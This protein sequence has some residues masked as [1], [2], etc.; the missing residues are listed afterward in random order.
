MPIPTPL[1]PRT[2]ALCESQEWRNWAGYLAA[3]TYEPTHEREYYAIRNAAALI[4]VSPLFKY[5]VN[6]SDALRLVNRIITR[7][8]A[9]CAVGQVMYSP[10]CDD[11]GMV[12]DDGTIARLEENRFRI[13]AAEPNLAW[14]QDCGVGLNAQVRDV[15][16]ELATLALQGPNA[17][18]ILLKVVND[19]NLEGLRYYRFSP[20]NMGGIPLLISRTGYTGDLG[21]EL[22]IDPQTAVKVWDKIFEE[23]EGFGIAPVGIVALDIARIEAGLVMLQV[24]YISARKALIEEQKSSPFELGLGWTVDLKK[25]YFIGR[26]ALLAEKRRG[27]QWNLVGVEVDWTSLEREFSGVNLVPQVVGRASRSAVPVYRD[28]WQIG[29]VSS[30]TFSPILKKYIGIATIESR[31]A[32]LGSPVEIEITV[33]YVRRKARATIVR[34]PFFDPPRKRA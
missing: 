9:R 14:F 19:A 10:W 15:S 32:E 18:S 3:G 2:A 4:D 17:R 13:T 1:H 7:N 8:V 21:Y 11:L 16:E 28:D 34:L 20:G 5:E 22:W 27:S 29:H 6:G 24:D 23:G 26:K 31:Y 25:E 33:E 12:I 30:H